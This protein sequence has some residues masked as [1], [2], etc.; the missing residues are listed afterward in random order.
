MGTKHELFNEFAAGIFGTC[1]N[2]YPELPPIP[3][4]NDKE[5]KFGIGERVW[6]INTHTIATEVMVLD[7]W[8]T[9]NWN[10]YRV[11]YDNDCVLMSRE[12]DLRGM[13]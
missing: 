9:N 2:K 10:R 7:R 6:E 5:F 4:G 12:K 1:S 13:K 8:K 3:P 11:K